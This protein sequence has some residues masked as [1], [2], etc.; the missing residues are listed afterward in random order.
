MRRLEAALVWLA[1]VLAAG[2]CALGLVGP[3][4]GKGPGLPGVVGFGIDAIAAL[5]LPGG[6][7]ALACALVA[8]R[9]RRKWPA[10]ILG[11]VALTIV[12]PDAWA[13]VRIKD[14][15]RASATPTLRIAAANLAEQNENDPFML[16]ALLDLDADVLVLPEYTHSWDRRLGAALRAHY[17]HF[18]LAS[19]PPQQKNVNV[20]GFR[21]AV[22]S[23]L[24]PAGEPEVIQLADVVAQI[25][26][27]LR[28]QGRDFALYGIHPRKP[29][30]LP[31]FRGAHRDRAQLLTWLAH[32]RL[33]MVVA[34]DFNATPRGAFLTRLRGRGLA[35]AAEAV[36]GTS[37]ATWPMYPATLAPFRVAIDHVLHSEAFA[38]VGFRT[39]AA[40]HSDH[41]AVVAELV[42]R[43]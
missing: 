4:L 40:T 12:G 6:V 11:V 35:N 23:R 26:V 28:W 13:R 24:P 27:P 39:G 15:L 41:A 38:A 5:W 14:T 17:A 7:L 22:W 32:E 36:L 8:L 10:A 18:F 9:R 34:G 2:A 29:F 21:L 42:W 1:A 20:D 19:P 16:D 25:R 30:P 3:H 43:D 31:F 33:P 37:P